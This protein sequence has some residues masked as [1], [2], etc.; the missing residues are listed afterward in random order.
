MLFSSTLVTMTACDNVRFLSCVMI[1]CS[2]EACI[3]VV[4]RGEGSEVEKRDCYHSQYRK[5]A[6]LCDQSTTELVGQS[7][8]LT[9]NW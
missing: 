6:A 7:S 1:E 9:C 8:R 2:E 4:E 5:G 3:R